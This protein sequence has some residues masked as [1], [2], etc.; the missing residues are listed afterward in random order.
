MIDLHSHST[1]SDGT[2]TPVA[3]LK[4]A[5]LAGIKTFAITDH[6]TVL[7]VMEARSSAKEVGIHLVNGVEISCSHTVVGGYG[8]NKELNKIIH[9]VALD[10]CDVQKM[11]HALQSLQDSRHHRGR[12]MIEKLA[13]LL[14]EDHQ[15]DFIEKIW[16]ATLYKAGHNPRAIGRAHIAQVLHDFGLVGSVQAAFDKYLADNKAA[17]VAIETLDMAETIR[18]IHDCG[19]L[20]VLAHPTRYGLSATRTRKLIADFA[21]LGGDG[22]ELPN[23]EPQSLRAM[24][25]RSI[26]QHDL[27]VSVG[28]DFHGDNMPWR[29]LGSVAK[30]KVGQVGVWEKFRLTKES[31]K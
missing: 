28:S 20:A 5:H 24:I 18:L 21:H 14:A 1:A 15:E 7:G 26:A 8:K 19:G 31:F 6:D 30:L 16:R 25:D 4:K 11:H 10:F 27:L 9:I 12:R 3:L 23:A 13:G 17:Y 2:D 22:C 29:K